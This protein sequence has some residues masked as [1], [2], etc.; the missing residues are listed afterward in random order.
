MKL[1]GFVKRMIVV[2]GSLEYLYIFD[3]VRGW[4]NTNSR[5]VGLMFSKGNSEIMIVP[6][7]PKNSNLPGVDWRLDWK[8][9]RLT[10]LGS[11]V[12]IEYLSEDFD[13]TN[14]KRWLTVQHKFRRPT[15]IFTDKK[16]INFSIR[17]KTLLSSR[18]IIA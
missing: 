14:R 6:W 3:V 17:S 1:L 13:D 4:K 5:N 11:I 10:R 8:K 7:K 16:E 12:E 9:L 2:N 18:G 15:A